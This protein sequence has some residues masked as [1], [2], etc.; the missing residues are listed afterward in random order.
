MYSARLSEPH[1]DLTVWFL[2][3]FLPKLVLTAA[4]TFFWSWSRGAVSLRLVD[5]RMTSSGLTSV[6]VRLNPA[7]TTE[8]RDSCLRVRSTYRCLMVSVWTTNRQRRPESVVCVQRC[9]SLVAF[10]PV[11]T[12]VVVIALS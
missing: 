6:G 9:A 12:A 3:R 8:D 2:A 4:S 7:G 11:G 5:L 1:S 10:T